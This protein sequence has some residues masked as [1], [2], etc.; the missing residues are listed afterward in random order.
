M[1]LSSDALPR[2]MSSFLHTSS[3]SPQEA[4]PVSPLL[5]PS[6]ERLGRWYGERLGHERQWALIVEPHRQVA[7]LIAHLL[8]LELGLQS[9]SLPGTRLIPSLFKRWAPDLVLAEIP[10]VQGIPSAEDLE[11]LRPVLD[12]AQAQGKP[13]PVILCTTY[14]EVSLEMA[15]SAG[16]AALIYKPFLPDALVAT[17]RSALLGHVAASRA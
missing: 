16:F 17:V 3:L 7:E 8:D 11:Y 5:T 1:Q 4:S 12:I 9:V 6:A 10:I 15:R 2:D 13:L 14:M